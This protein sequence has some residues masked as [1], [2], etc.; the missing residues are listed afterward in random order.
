MVVSIDP[1]RVWVRTA[2]DADSHNVVNHA[3]A[4]GGD[5]GV[6][7]PNGEPVLVRV[8]GA[9]RAE[10]SGLDVVQV[11]QAV[12]ALGGEILLN[13]I[14]NDGQNNGFDLGLVASVKEPSRSR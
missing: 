12:E 4:V 3:D 9:G 11:C 1:R 13:C 6:R 7:G 10:G 14:D 8:H 2:A 5:R